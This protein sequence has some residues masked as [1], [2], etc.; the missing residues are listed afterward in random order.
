MGRGRV[1]ALPLLMPETHH[2]VSETV[3]ETVSSQTPLY[4]EMSR[5][6]QG[7]KSQAGA[8][9]SFLTRHPHRDLFLMFLILDWNPHL[10]SL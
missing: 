10:I 3:S 1:G 7:H 4:T 5:R 6:A 8:R 9:T 2:T